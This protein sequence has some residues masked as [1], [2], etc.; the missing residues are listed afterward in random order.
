[1]SIWRRVGRRVVGGNKNKGELQKNLRLLEFS[2]IRLSLGRY[3]LTNL[4]SIPI[5][6][7]NVN[8]KYQYY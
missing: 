3:C 8:K 5:T 4:P 6:T 1:L 7:R 2:K